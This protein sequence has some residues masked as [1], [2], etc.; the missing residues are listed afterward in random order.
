MDGSGG[1]IL[2]DRY[3]NAVRDKFD[4]R[5]S[6]YIH[7]YR[8]PRSISQDAKVQ[9]LKAAKAWA[10]AWR[11][12]AVLDLGCG[13]GVGLREFQMSAAGGLLVGMDLSME[14][15]QVARV[16]CP[17]ATGLVQADV[18]RFPLASQT[19][20]LVLSLGVFGYLADQEGFLAET[21]RVL[22][23]GGHLIFNFP[24]KDQVFW[25]WRKKAVT[26]DSKREPSPK[27]FSPRQVADM[28]ERAGFHT[29]SRR[30]LVYGLAGNKGPQA[31]LVSRLAGRI[32]GGFSLGR[33]LGRS[34][35]MAARRS[36]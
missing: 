36:C 1:I 22:R 14:M 5:A 17:G 35:L 18:T 23:P 29:I 27:A 30:F 25:Q 7:N 31:V 28:L 2:M 4:R 8:L 26:R 34:C 19:F 12:S 24:N 6:T 11:S 21:G 16:V 9:R 3:R 32:L 20:D 15:L 10:E 33:I 13:P